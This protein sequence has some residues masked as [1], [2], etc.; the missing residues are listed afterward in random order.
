MTAK[1]FREC[2]FLVPFGALAL[3]SGCAS[4]VELTR[5]G[6]DRIRVDATTQA[7][8]Q[9]LIGKPDSELSGLW[10]YHR[11]DA[12]LEVMIDFDDQG[13][14]TRKQ[15]IDGLGNDWHD[16]EEGVGDVSTGGR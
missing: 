7:E 8:V 4:P 3:S 1:R 13:L 5:S 12:H 9:D 16:S 6:F 15:W 11:P 14:V 10:L 2:A